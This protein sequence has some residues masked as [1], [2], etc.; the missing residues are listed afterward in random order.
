[1][2]LA[3]LRER[4]GEFIEAIQLYLKGGLPGKAASL[5]NQHQESVGNE[6][7]E[8]IAVSL[9]RAGLFEKV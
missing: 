7:S 3:E 4:D 2:S 6:I 9:Y 1:M 5:L 8:S